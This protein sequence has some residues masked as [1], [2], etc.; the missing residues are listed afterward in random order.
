MQILENKYLNDMKLEM[1]K[2]SLIENSIYKIVKRY[3]NEGKPSVAY[4][5]TDS[6]KWK[7]SDK[8]F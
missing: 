8:R 3:Y 4:S 6:I 1:G 7:N 5:R 2:G